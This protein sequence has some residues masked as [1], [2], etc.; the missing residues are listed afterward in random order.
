MRDSEEVT[1]EFNKVTDHKCLE[2]LYEIHHRGVDRT[3]SRTQ[4]EEYVKDR[5]CGRNGDL[6]WRN[7]VTVVQAWK[8]EI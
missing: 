8:A 4:Q 5:A 6:L 3:V 7:K 2:K 1:G